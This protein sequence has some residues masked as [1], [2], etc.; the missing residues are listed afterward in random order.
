MP[1]ASHDQWNLD[2]LLFTPNNIVTASE[3]KLFF[4]LIDERVDS[5]YNARAIV[6][7]EWLA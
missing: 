4:G 2:Q 1:T 6:D 3:R 7:S 5:L